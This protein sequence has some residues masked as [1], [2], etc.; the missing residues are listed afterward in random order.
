M[1]HDISG[2]LSHILGVLGIIFVTLIH[3]LIEMHLAPSLE[4]FVDALQLFVEPLPVILFFYF[5]KFFFAFFDVLHSGGG[6]AGVLRFCP[7]LNWQV[8]TVAAG[9]AGGWGG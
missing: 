3:S 5:V 6:A 1:F 4:F 7:H 8:R 2:E 9:E